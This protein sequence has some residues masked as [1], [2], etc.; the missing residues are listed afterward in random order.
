MD[1]FCKSAKS[2]RRYIG[3]YIPRTNWFSKLQHKRHDDT[4]TIIAQMQG[5]IKTNL[6][7]TNHYL[8]NIY[9]SF[10]MITWGIF[11]LN[12]P[13]HNLSIKRQTQW[14]II[15]G[16]MPSLIHDHSLVGL[17]VLILVDLLILA[18]NTISRPATKWIM[19]ECVYRQRQYMIPLTGLIIN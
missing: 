10:Y 3:S 6:A 1:L 19:T 14:K 5:R 8:H 13:P 18:C 7:M 11:V 12:N 16:H 17:C 9:F 15:V 2:C 4:V